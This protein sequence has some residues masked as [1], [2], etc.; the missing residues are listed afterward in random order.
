MRAHPSELVLAR[1]AAGDAMTDEDVLAAARH[2]GQCASC[3]AAVGYLRAAESRSAGRGPDERARRSRAAG[4]QPRDA[5]QR[6]AGPHPRAPGRAA[7]AGHRGRHDAPE[8]T[9]APRILTV[10]RA[11]P[12][13]T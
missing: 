4:P 1:I 3:A 13:P 5:D 2:V 12:P 8:G 7:G 6:K 10:H 11:A 9:V